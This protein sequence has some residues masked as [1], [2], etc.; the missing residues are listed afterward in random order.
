MVLGSWDRKRA[1]HLYRRAGFGGSREE[2]DAAVSLGR[3]GAVGYL[4]D[5]ENVSSQELDA[6]LGQYGFDLATLG[7]DKGTRL[8]NLVRWWFWRMQYTP[9]PLEEK[10]TLFWHNH[11]ATS[12]NKL[13]EPGF[14]YG[15]N[16]IF[17]SLGMGSFGDL[18]LAVSR[19]PAMLIW[20]DNVTNVKNRP[21]EN[22]AR[23]VM[24]LFTMGVGHYS[25]RDVTEAARAFTGWTLDYETGK[26]LFNADVHDDEAKTVL[27]KRGFFRGEDVIAILASRPETAAYIGAKL[28]RSFLGGNPSPGLSQRLVDVYFST[29][30]MIRELVRAILLSDDFDQTADSAD[31]VKSPIEIIVGARKSLGAYDDP[32]AY[33]VWPE[34][35]GLALFRPPNVGG[36]KG[37]RSWI[38]TASLLI[39]MRIAFSIVTQPSPAGEWF[40]WDLGRFFADQSFGNADEL[41]DFLS[42]RFNLVEP[43]ETFRQSLRQWVNHFGAFTWS[44]ESADRFGR[45]AIALLMSSP[46]YQ[47]Q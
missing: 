28:A 45:A 19:D 33:A 39:R 21:N 34:L 12:N 31:M 25:Q 38:T 13:D 18:L 11:F 29:G 26:Y 30:G 46:E 24:E 35:M 27:G 23:E 7:G 8:N 37:G 40:R 10:M 2:L 47:V 20:L 43:S 3:E 9:R 5:Y 1:A 4:V 44:L 16:Q 41:I 15:Q 14:M 42:D 22:F 6:F 17:R 32:N 36:W